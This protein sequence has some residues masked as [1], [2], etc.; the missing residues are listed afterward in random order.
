MFSVF[1]MAI[2]LLRKVVVVDQRQR[3]VTPRARARRECARTP[4]ARGDRGRA[5]TGARA[6]PRADARECARRVACELARAWR[7][8]AGR[9]IVDDLLV[10]FDR[11]S[12]GRDAG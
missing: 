1:I 8:P 9:M 5:R 12:Y 10:L 2:T 11:Y 6:G 4:H 3:A 7:F